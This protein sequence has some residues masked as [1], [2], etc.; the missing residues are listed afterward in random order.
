MVREL[1]ERGSVSGWPKF[2]KKVCASLLLSVGLSE[3][4]NFLFLVYR[5]EGR[6]EG[7]APPTLSDSET[8]AVRRRV[9]LYF[10]CVL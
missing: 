1:K 7:C 10:G 3:S 4:V 5:S 8:A 2:R 9:S 6:K